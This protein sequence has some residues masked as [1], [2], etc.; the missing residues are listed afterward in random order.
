MAFMHGIYAVRG[1]SVGEVAI[2][3]ATCLVAVGSTKSGTAGKM[4]ICHNLEEFHSEFGDGSGDADYKNC[5]LEQVAEYGF[6]Y[7]NLGEIVFISCGDDIEDVGDSVG[8]I[9]KVYKML[10]RR[11]NLVVAPGVGSVSGA[12]PLLN[13]ACENVVGS[14]SFDAVAFVNM[15]SHNSVSEYV[16]AKS[17]MTKSPRIAYFAGKFA[18]TNKD[19]EVAVVAAVEQV[20]IDAKHSDLPYEI[21]SN[22]VV[23]PFGEIDKIYDRD[24]GNVLGAAGINC[25]IFDDGVKLWGG[26][27]ST[28]D[29]ETGVDGDEVFISSVRMIN[30]RRDVFLKRNAS[31]IDRPLTRQTIDQIIQSEQSELDRLV[32][33]GAL[34][35][36][37]KIT[38]EAVDNPTSQMVSGNFVWNMTITPTVPFASGTLVVRWTAD[39]FNSLVE[40]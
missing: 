7:G 34:I 15:S 10:H 8:E 39:G 37:P 33:L 38:F 30:N 28:F 17:S 16:Q 6:K 21:A 29:S 31:K 36:S 32:A 25:V 1:E 14:K 40:G 2:S 24:E 4:A 35:G 20:K 9:K 11:P 27:L 18:E 3:S 22:V 23:S 26:Y 13:S 19:L 5:T 12:I